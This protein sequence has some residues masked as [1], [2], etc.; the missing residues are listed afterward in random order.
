MGRE[1]SVVPVVHREVLKARKHMEV[2]L[3]TG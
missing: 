1:D 3:A 2:A